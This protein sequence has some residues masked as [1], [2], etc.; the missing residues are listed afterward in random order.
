VRT[1]NR[2]LAPRWL[3]LLGREGFERV[4]MAGSQRR[5]GSH[6]TVGGAL[7]RDAKNGGRKGTDVRWQAAAPRFAST[8]LAFKRGRARLAGL[9]RAIGARARCTGTGAYAA[10]RDDGRSRR[11]VQLV[12]GWQQRRRQRKQDSTVWARVHSEWWRFCWRSKQKV[13]G[14]ES[15]LWA[16]NI[17]VTSDVVLRHL[18]EGVHS[19]EKSIVMKSTISRSDCNVLPYELRQD[20]RCCGGKRKGAELVLVF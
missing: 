14:R 13:M 7:G 6:G 5:P 3:A 19:G 2:S 16:V 20:F 12:V 4:N 18:D 9:R 11:L 8:L 17:C 1:R 10:R 15:P